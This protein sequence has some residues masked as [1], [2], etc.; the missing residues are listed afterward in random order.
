MQELGVVRAMELWRP[1]PG[2][3]I[4]N[5]HRIGDAA[6][7]CFDRGVFSASAEQLDAQVKYFKK[8]AEILTGEEMR[9][10]ALGQTKVGRFC[11]FF[12]F[13]DG[14]LDNYHS[15]YKV[16]QSNGATGAFF[17]VTSYVGTATIPWWD[18][19]A[20]LVRH[21]SEAEIRLSY[22]APLKLKLGE[23]REPAIAAIL[24]HFK[25]PDNLDSHRFMND[26]RAATAA[27]L[28]RVPRRF[29][30][31]EE[32]R[33]MRDAGMEI[34]SHT[35]T[36]PI[37]SR[38]S[39]EAQKAELESSKREIEQRLGS[40]VLALA[41]PDGAKSCFNDITMKA[42][43]SAGYSMCFSFYGGVNTGRTVRR[44]NLLR[45]SMPSN[46]EMFRAKAAM[47]AAIGWRSSEA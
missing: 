4:V 9:S 31:W 22:P 33:E 46:P 19:I 39:A 25:R 41:Y 8:H 47:I 34:G 29:L 12:T 20:Y 6:R 24:E 28:P 37:L 45:R 3:L 44:A 10:I 32:A 35:T 13:D 23:A 14:Y 5:H 30:S 11:V 15:A 36:H 43:L 38:L 1:Q 2:V 16:L 27:D 42:A 26:L 21:T 40:D 18:E 17:L 7:T